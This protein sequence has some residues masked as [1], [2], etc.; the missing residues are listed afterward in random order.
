MSLRMKPI[1][2]S[3]F[4]QVT[5]VCDGAH[6]MDVTQGRK[7]ALN[8][9]AFERFKTLRDGFRAYDV[10]TFLSQELL[11]GNPVAA[12]PIAEELVH[13]SFR[14]LRLTTTARMAAYLRNTLLLRRLGK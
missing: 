5:K 8:R 14:H 10:S 12:T 2:I 11:E 3:P 1:E 9:L 7:F 4:L 13:S 6:I